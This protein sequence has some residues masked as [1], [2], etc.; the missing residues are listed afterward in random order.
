MLV[1]TSKLSSIG[2]LAS[3]FAHNIN[4]PFNSIM[5]NA[6]LIKMYIEEEVRENKISKERIEEFKE[7]LSYIISSA[8]IGSK[9]VKSIMEFSKPATG[10]RIPLDLREVIR[11]SFMIS[12]HKIDKMNINKENRQ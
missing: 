8:D 2:E 10:Q 9:I 4:N 5:V 1:Q 3:G 6:G 12:T 11:K 7:Y